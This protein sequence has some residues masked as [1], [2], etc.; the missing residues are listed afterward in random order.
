MSNQLQQH[1]EEIDRS[2]ADIQLMGHIAIRAAQD[3]RRCQDDTAHYCL[4][5]QETAML[6]FSVHDVLDRLE[7]L[8]AGL[9]AAAESPGGIGE[10]KKPVKAARKGGRK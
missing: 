1:L 4:P 10:P 3:L 7:K 6:L 8:R 2:L 5:E 9:S